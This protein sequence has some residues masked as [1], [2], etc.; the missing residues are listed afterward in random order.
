MNT[1][2]LFTP[3][4][5]A[6]LSCSNAGIF[7]ADYNGTY[8][9]ANKAFCDLTGYSPEEI[10]SRKIGDLVHPDDAIIERSFITDALNRR[11]QDIRMEIRFITKS[12]E[13][14]W[15]DVSLSAYTDE[16]NNVVNLIGVVKDISDRKKTELLLKEAEENARVLINAPKESIFM[17]KPDGSVIYINETTAER[18][19][20][21]VDEMIGRPI[22]LFASS[23]ISDRRK[24]YL[25]KA[26]ES[27]KPVHFIDERY[28]RMIENSLYPILDDMGK[29]SRIAIYGRDITDRNKIEDTLKLMSRIADD[30]PASITIHDFEGNML[31]CNEETLRIH[32]YTREEFLAINL[33][34]LDV[35]ESEHQIAERMQMIR[36]KG[37]ADFESRHFKKDGTP[38]PLHV[39]VKRITWGDKQVLLSIATDITER[40]QIE[41][42]IRASEEKYRTVVERAHDGIIITD[43][44][45]V[46]FSND[47]FSHM[48]GYLVH[49]LTGMDFMKLIPQENRTEIMTAIQNRITGA[50]THN[51]YETNLIR[52]DHS[53]FPVDISTGIIEFQGN[54]ADLIIIRDDSERRRR[55]EEK[56]STLHLLNQAQSFTKLGGWEYD[57]RSGKI[58][59]TDEVYIIHGVGHD[60]DP[61]NIDADINFYTPK[62]AIIIKK[63]FDKAVEEGIP[64]DLE[65]QFVRADGK[66]IWIRTMAN[67]ERENGT[68]VRVTGYIMDITERKEMEL[69]LR[70][71]ITKLKI[72]TGIT[73]H[74]VINDLSIIS[75]S[76]EMARESEDTATIY[77]YIDSAIHA[78]KTLEKTIGFTR[79]YED[80]GSISSR[81]IHLLSLI[82]SAY[83]DLSLPEDMLSLAIPHDIEVYTDFIFK[84]VFTTL[85]ENSVRH[86][87]TITKISVFVKESENGLII[88]YTDDGTGIMS[89]E[90]ELIF[91]HGYGRHTGIGLFLARQILSISGFSI[92]ETGE[93][94]NGVRFEITVPENGFRY[95]IR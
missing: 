12:N 42:I 31:Y 44:R 5:N 83:A 25:T 21:T 74:D 65:L 76:L 71:A 94:G 9:Y 90:K 86:G 35:P 92:R 77:H 56:K 10:I 48:S 75:L 38:V 57:V 18:L 84:K 8:L 59:W 60:Y 69:S 3:E 93:Y 4:L 22:F 79:D 82:K 34:N 50:G 55:E 1:P 51:S 43:G 29:V 7:Y 72:L 32:G 14:R 33:H 91:R 15:G 20:Y 27:G 67:P 53:F 87:G 16:K 58:T 78:G 17:V 89:E 28:G 64:Y 13:I 24:V 61:N 37:E 46:L 2:S 63:A 39:N 23:E 66:Q 85:F 45:T 54:P 70:E 52:Q 6:I 41:E 11:A 30:A 73:R 40:K 68:V 36:E 47:A 80:F 26:L 19:G 81:W 95:Q 62:D 49:E 88:V